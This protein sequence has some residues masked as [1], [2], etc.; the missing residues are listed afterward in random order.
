MEVTALAYKG[1]TYTITKGLLK[2]IAYNV[3]D[4]LSGPAFDQFASILLAAAGLSFADGKLVLAEYVPDNA[5][6]NAPTTTAPAGGGGSA[7]HTQDDEGAT[8]DGSSPADGTGHDA[9]MPD[10]T[11]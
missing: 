10:G 11:C 6:A 7:P 5:P 1:K 3:I 4:Q 8:P 2:L 9:P